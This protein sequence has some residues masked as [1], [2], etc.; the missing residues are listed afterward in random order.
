MRRVGVWEWDSGTDADYLALTEIGHDM[1]A[2]T[3]ECGDP[4]G[5]GHGILL[6]FDA[7]DR[8]L[9]I[10]VLCASDRLPVPLVD[11]GAAAEAERELGASR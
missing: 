3:I 6:D 8:L 1:V 4:G 7:R 9:G 11:Y 10:E 5:S 2:K